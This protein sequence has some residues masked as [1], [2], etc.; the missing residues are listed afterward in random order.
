MKVTLRWLQDFAPFDQSVDVL[1]DTMSDLGHGGRGA[2]DRGRGPGRHRRG[3]GART[4]PPPQRRPHPAGRRRPGRRRSAADRLWRV[5][6][7]GG[8][9]GAAGHGRHGHAQRHGDRGSQ[10]AGRDVQR[11]VVLRRRAG[12]GRGRRRDHGPLGSPAGHAADRG[13]GHRTGRGLGPRGQRQPA[14]RHVGRRRRPRRRRP[15]GCAVHDARPRDPRDRSR[16]RHPGIG[17]DP[18]PGAVRSV[19]GPGAPERHGRAR[20][21]VDGQPA[22]RGRHALDQQRGGRVQLRHGRAGPAQPHLRP[23]HGAGRGPAGAACRSRARP[24]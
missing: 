9:P 6:H 4:A 12:H 24:W 7:G 1:G 16:R 2:L 14:R 18:R 22:G 11:D 5:Q 8:R 10:D 17:R 21:P 23:G 3:R 13:H 20:A 15:P 19:P